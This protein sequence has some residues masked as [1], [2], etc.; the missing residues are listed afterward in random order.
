MSHRTAAA[1]ELMHPA[2]AHRHPLTA[3][4][5]DH[6]KGSSSGTPTEETEE[7]EEEEDIDACGTSKQKFRRFSIDDTSESRRRLVLVFLTK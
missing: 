5:Q 4:Q 3:S 2:P 7:E 1:P 6:R